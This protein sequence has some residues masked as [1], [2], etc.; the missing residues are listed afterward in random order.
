MQQRQVL[1]QSREP[2]D[3][4]NKE[5]SRIEESKSSRLDLKEQ[6]MF[7]KIKAQMV[8]LPCQKL[9]QERVS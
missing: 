9:N 3:R 1:N 8:T 5:V 6:I 2:P 4:I 7:S